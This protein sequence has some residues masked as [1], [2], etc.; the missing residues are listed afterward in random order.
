M[1]HSLDHKVLEAREVYEYYQQTDISTSRPLAHQ[2]GFQSAYQARAVISRA[3]M[4]ATIAMDTFAFRLGDIGFIGGTYEM[5][6]SAS[7]YVRQNSPFDTTV[8]I[9]G[10]HSYVASEAAF[11]QNTYEA[12]TGYYAK[13]TSE[14]MAEHYVSMLN[15]LTTPQGE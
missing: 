2:Y 12:V 11:D 7:N 5:Y 9:C 1:D 14:K 3:N 15:K 6:S 8:V 13:G 4:A 10:N